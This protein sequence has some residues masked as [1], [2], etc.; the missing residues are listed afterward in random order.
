M[1][2]EAGTPTLTLHPT[3]LKSRVETQIPIKMTLHPMPPGVT[4]LHLPTHTISKPKLLAKPK[5]GPSPDMLELHTMLVCSSAMQA[6]GRLERAFQRAAGLV[7]TKREDSR[8]SSSGDVPAPDDDESKPL[9]GGEVG[10]CMG[11]ITRER[12]R[13]ARKKVKKA[14]EE[15]CW[16]E[17]EHKRIVVF[18]TYEIKEWQQ[19]S[20][21][22]MTEVVV[23]VV[24]YA[25]RH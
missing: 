6:P 11:C 19:P 17:D 22:N 15:D 13:A 8:R 1:P 12:K 9:N 20:N 7:P 14:E 10:I 16:Y 24:D 4:K 25:R 18:N 5:P 23:V 21:E 2:H 3:P